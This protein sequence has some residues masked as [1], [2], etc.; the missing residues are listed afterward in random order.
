MG[1]S[2]SLWLHF[3]A[4]LASAFMV[5]SMWLTARACFAKEGYGSTAGRLAALFAAHGMFGCLFFAGLSYIAWA[6]QHAVAKADP[7][8][9]YAVAMGML[10]TGGMAFV[11]TGI[12]W[13]GER[14]GRTGLW[15]AY[16]FASAAWAATGVFL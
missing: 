15:R 12:G 6:W 2:F 1:V 8:L 10:A 4:A 16:L 14:A 9:A 13:V 11:K 7:A 3:Q 5:P